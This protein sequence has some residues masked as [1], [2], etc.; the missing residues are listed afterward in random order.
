VKA[1]ARKK[2]SQE[3]AKNS[4]EGPDKLPPEKEIVQGFWGNRTQF[5]NPET[6]QWAKR[7]RETGQ[8]MEV[9]D[10]PYQAVPREH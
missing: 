3:M 6:G 9:K 2:V 7:D 1:A 4:S 8:L 5:Q 10:E